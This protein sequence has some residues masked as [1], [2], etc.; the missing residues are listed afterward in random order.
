MFDTFSQTGGRCVW[1]DGIY[2]LERYLARQHGREPVVTVDW[3]LA[4]ELVALSEGR[5]RVND[6][7]FDLEHPSRP[8]QP[9]ERLSHPARD[10]ATHGTCSVLRTP[11]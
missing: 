9:V 2:D 11:P 3:G 6:V 8:S 5:L 1:S 4:A 7:E 10:R